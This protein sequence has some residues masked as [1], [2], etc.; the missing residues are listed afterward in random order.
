MKGQRTFFRMPGR[1]GR[2]GNRSFTVEPLFKSNGE[3]WG[4]PDLKNQNASFDEKSDLK[5]RSPL[6]VV[7][8]K[9]RFSPH[10]KAARS[11]A[12]WSLSGDSDSPASV[13]PVAGDQSFMNM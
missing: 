13:F 8:S 11:Q 12:V 5:G 6:A 4:E 10:P 9:K 2:G 1:L 3:H 7:V